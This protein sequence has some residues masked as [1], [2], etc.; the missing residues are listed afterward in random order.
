MEPR[1]NT[2]LDNKDFNSVTVI[3]TTLYFCEV[4]KLVLI[5]KFQ[6][7]IQIRITWGFSFFKLDVFG[8][9]SSSEYFGKASTKSDMHL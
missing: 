1:V 2:S 8:I 9:H 7:D 3:S 5:G 6:P 4:L